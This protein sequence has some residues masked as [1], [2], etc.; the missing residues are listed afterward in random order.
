MFYSFLSITR[1]VQG[2]PLKLGSCVFEDL[3]EHYFQDLIKTMGCEPQIEEV[4]GCTCPFNLKWVRDM[5]L[6]KTV[7]INLW[8]FRTLDV[9]IDRMTLDLSK[10]SKSEALLLVGTFEVRLETEDAS[11][12][13]GCLNMTFTTQLNPNTN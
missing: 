3:C 10:V 5:R 11:G 2:V 1:K 8:L 4:V 9:N 7:F 12:P 13:L 6:S